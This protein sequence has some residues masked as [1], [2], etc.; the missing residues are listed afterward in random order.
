MTAYE[1][2]YQYQRATTPVS[3]IPSVYCAHLAAA[4]GMSHINILAKAPLAERHYNEQNPL[5]RL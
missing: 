4:R 5:A 2:C 3:L 1:H